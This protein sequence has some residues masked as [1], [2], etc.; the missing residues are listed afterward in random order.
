[1]LTTMMIMMKIPFE[2]PQGSHLYLFYSVIHKTK[3]LQKTDSNEKKS[4]LLQ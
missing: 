1:M 4:V 3:N 2:N